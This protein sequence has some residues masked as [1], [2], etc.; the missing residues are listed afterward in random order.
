MKSPLSLS[1][2][3]LRAGLIVTVLPLLTMVL[4]GL[5][6]YEQETARV[7]SFTGKQAVS[8]ARVAANFLDFMV[9][10]TRSVIKRIA[11]S[12]ETGRVTTATLK[13]EAANQAQTDGLEVTDVA[14]RIILSSIGHQGRNITSLTNIPLLTASHGF[15]Y[16]DVYFSPALH[17]NVVLLA[18]P[19]H[20]R[21]RFAGLVLARFNLKT[22]SRLLSDRL[23]NAHLAQIFIVDRRGHLIAKNE[24]NALP[25]GQ[26]LLRDPAVEAALAGKSAWMKYRMPGHQAPM[27]SG[28][29]QMPDTG[30]AVVSSSTVSEGVLGVNKRLREQIVLASLAALLTGL[31][32]F[33]WG[34]RLARPLERLEATIREARNSGFRTDLSST[35]AQAQVPTEL[36]EYRSLATGYNEMAAELNHR[37]AEVC[38]L[39]ETLEAKNGEL[40]VQNENLTR[41]TAEAQASNQLKSEFL[42]KMSHELRTPLN[43]IIGFTQLAL[44]DERIDFDPETRQDLEIVLRSARHLLSVINDVLDLSKIEAGRTSLYVEPLNLQ[45]LIPDVIETTRPFAEAHRVS[46]HSR[47]APELTTIHSDAVRLR[48]IALNLMSNAIKFTPAGGEVTISVDPTSVGDWR[49]SV[50][51]TGIGIAPEHQEMIFEEF[52][53]VDGSTTRTSGGTGLGLSISRKLARMLGGDLTVE[54]KLGCGSTFTLTLPRQPESRESAA[55]VVNDPIP[56]PFDPPASGSILVISEDPFSLHLMLENLRGSSEPVVPVASGEAGLQLASTL[57]PSVVLLDVKLRREE[58]WDLLRRFKSDPLLRDIPLVV[59]SY[60]SEQAQAFSLGATDFVT[61]PITRDALLE[62]LARATTHPIG[63]A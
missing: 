13:F 9:D 60:E 35:M 62:T 26:S 8:S 53:Q 55:S 45:V 52:R 11:L 36:A 44:T 33:L 5:F 24:A 7:E 58:D 59:A 14:G 34:R 54:S 23:N 29:V 49:L 51:D 30:W 3:L 37:F 20:V 40:Q 19:Y 38:A 17:Q 56:A 6:Q 10:D 31:A 47:V 43:S 15:V 12:M 48:Q 63:N 4:L 16:S 18:A 22:V 50:T 39:K 42:A 61:K 27:I 28:F 1:Q 2:H 46:V 57:N 25:A 41:L 21:G 32:A